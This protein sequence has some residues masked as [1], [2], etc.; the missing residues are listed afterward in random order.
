[1]V[2]REDRL[3]PR[4]KAGEPADEGVVLVAVGKHLEGAEEVGG[5]D[6]ALYDSGSSV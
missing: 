3:G 1:V 6:S 4:G 2:G 5:G